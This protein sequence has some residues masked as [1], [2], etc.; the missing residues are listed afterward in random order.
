MVADT[1]M[2]PWKIGEVLS[3]TNEEFKVVIFKKE[4]ERKSCVLPQVSGGV[5]REGERFSFQK[6]TSHMLLFSLSLNIK[7]LFIE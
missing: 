4:Q 2:H 3:W 7:R 1:E 5:H 6:L